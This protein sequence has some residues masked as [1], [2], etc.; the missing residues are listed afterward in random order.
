L[1]GGRVGLAT[2]RVVAGA[3][4]PLTAVALGIDKTK[5]HR[6]YD[7]VSRRVEHRHEFWDAV[8]ALA[9]AL[10]EGALLSRY[11]GTLLTPGTFSVPDGA[12]WRSPAASIGS[13][14]SSG[15]GTSPSSVS[16]PS[17][18]PMPDCPAAAWSAQWR[19]VVVAAARGRRGVPDPQSGD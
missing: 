7:T 16:L 8:H 14:T 1:R 9:E 4:W 3:S 12:A 17:R 18:S 10:D 15:V 5:A 11:H 13:P 6:C 2:A 19:R